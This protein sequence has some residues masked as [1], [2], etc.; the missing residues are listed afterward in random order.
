V[1][2][3]VLS[4]IHDR[5]DR[6]RDLLTVLRPLSVEALVLCGDITRPQTLAQCQLPGARLSYCLGNCDQG[7]QDELLDAALT[8]QARAFPSLGRLALPEG[9]ALAF[10]HFPA[11]ARQAAQSGLYRAV[12]YG[13]THRAA[14]ETL[15]LPGG[16]VLLANPGDVEGRYGRLSALLYDSVDR[17][18]T[19]IEA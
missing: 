6:L 13:H 2:I 17:S 19:L 4:D 14:Q 1:L 9:G 15:A 5:T 3:A 11:Q 12:F 18:C 10:C 16:A 8:L 7:R